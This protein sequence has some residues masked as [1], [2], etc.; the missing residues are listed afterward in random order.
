MEERKSVSLGFL[1]FII[2]ATSERRRRLKLSFVVR[3]GEA[4]SGRG[5]MMHKLEWL[6][7]RLTLYGWVSS[8]IREN[9]VG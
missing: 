3:S 5:R 6:E 2:H 8:F 4:F 1:N 9:R 7:E